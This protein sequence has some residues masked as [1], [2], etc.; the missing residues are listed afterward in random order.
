MNKTI[1]KTLFAATLFFAC[2]A[3]AHAQLPN[4]KFGKPSS[5]EWDYV[6]WNDA[7]DADAII[8]CKTMKVTYQISDQV[9]TSY[10]GSDM[11]FSNLADF[12]KNQIDNGNILVNYEF[13]LRM[14]ILKPEGRRHADI[15]ITYFNA[16]NEKTY[17]HDEL[18]DMKINVFTR[19]EKGKAVKRK[20]DTRSFAT[21]RIDDNY[22]VMHVVVPEVEAGSIIEY[23][24]KITSN[25]PTYLYDWVFQETIPTV[26]SKFDIDIPAFL[27]FKMN[28][29]IHKIIKSSVEV[30]RLA[31]DQYRADMKKGKSFPTNHYIVYGD[32]ILPE[33]QVLQ[34]S[35]E[36]NGEGNKPQEEPIAIFTSQIVT[37]HEVD[38]APMPTGHTH[39][40]V[41]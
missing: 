30:G 25:R 34:G 16:D 27:Q 36:G 21:E 9:S 38:P 40:K 22:M 23:Q 39:L 26:R 35:K 5:M 17:N 11:S 32:Y 2:A 28:V 4:E 37:P 10:E 14:K 8:L 31:Y 15:D 29:P 1:S 6:G 13:K 12:G 19:N 33:G 7:P 3:M 41:K 20:V 24:Y 18:F